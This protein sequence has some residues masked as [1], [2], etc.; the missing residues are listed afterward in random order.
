MATNMCGKKM[1]IHYDDEIRYVFI[2]I[3]HNY[4]N[5]LKNILFWTSSKEEERVWAK[6]VRL[7][8]MFEIEWKTPHHNIL[9]EFMNNWKLDPKNNII[10]FMLGGD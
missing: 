1:R 10:K 7:V 6:K 2:P 4:N 3:E 5:N 9:V 8:G